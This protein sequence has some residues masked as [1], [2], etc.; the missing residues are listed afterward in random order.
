MLV[1]YSWLKEFINLKLPAER[2]GEKLSLT[3]IGVEEVKKEGR[4]YLLNLDVTYNRGDLLSII[5]VA[6]EL[7]ALLNL[8]LQ[9]EEESFHPPS[10]LTNLSIKSNKALSCLYTL[11]LIRNLSY[12]ETPEKIKRYLELAGMRPINLF[13]DITNYVMLEWGQPFHAFDAEKIRNRDK[14]FAIEVRN[15]KRGETIKTLDG[16]THNLEPHD[17]VIADRKGPIAIAGVMGGQ[18]TEVESSTKEIL[19]E[20]AIFDPT[21]IRRTSHRLGLR[22]EA[23]TRFEHFLSPENLLKALSRA[24]KLYQLYGKG[25]VF[26]FNQIGET[27]IT[28][29]AINLSVTKLNSLLGTKIDLAV[30]RNCLKRLGFKVMLGDKGLIAWPPHFRGDILCEEDLIEEVARL[31]GYDNLPATPPATGTVGVP[32]NDFEYFRGYLAELLAGMGFSEVRSYPFLSTKALMHRGTEGLLKLKNPISAE[33]EYLKDSNFLNLLEIAQK[34]AARYKEGRLFELEKVYPKEGE[35]FA[36][37][38]ILWGTTPYRTLKGVSETLLTKAYLSYDFT[39]TKHSFLHPGR[40]AKVLANGREI[41]ILGELHPHLGE[42]YGLKD[43]ALFELNLEKLTKHAQRW[44]TFTPI[45]PYPEVYEDFSFFFP[46]KKPLG[47]L[48]QKIKTLD[49]VI[50]EVELA[51]LFEQKGERS[52]TL[53]LTFQSEIKELSSKDLKPTREKVAK[54]IRKFGGKLRG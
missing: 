37:T 19:L 29:Q 35:Y 53:R 45:P 48:L 20:A 17:I 51:D 49:R 33:A 1:P 22:S 30:A 50:R 46:Y 32:S 39:P 16:S 27:T 47:P 24:V 15:A 44:K 52:V 6:R 34:N 4:E 31:Y 8:K 36:L 13:A 18:D 26:G 23:S 42:S 54:L 41:G 9:K 21:S 2:V 12:Q 3:T 25:E 43:V 40:V 5:G 14:T 38:G 11:V 28:P 7:A 10:G